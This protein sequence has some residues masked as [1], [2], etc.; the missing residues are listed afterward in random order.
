MDRRHRPLLSNTSVSDILRQ[1]TTLLLVLALFSA[2][3]CGG[4]GATGDSGAADGAA[5]ESANRHY[6][7]VIG[8]ESELEETG[9]TFSVTISSPYDSPQQYADAWR[10]LGPDGTELGFRLLTHD[11]ASEQPFTRNQRGI[12]IPDDIDIVTVQGRDLLNGWG[13]G[14][15]QHELER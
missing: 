12:T 11:H 14:T 2:S 3:A 10:V 5:S 8:V 9:W 1:A 15:M 7:D 4:G 6:P 13:G